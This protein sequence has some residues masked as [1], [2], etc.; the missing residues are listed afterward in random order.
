M[1]TMDAGLSTAWRL[2]GLA[3]G[4]AAPVAT[5]LLPRPPAAPVAVEEEAA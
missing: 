3:R 2:G 4:D 1:T 5:L